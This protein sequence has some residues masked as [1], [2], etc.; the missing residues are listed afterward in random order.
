MQYFVQW[1]ICIWDQPQIRSQNWESNL[2]LCGIKT[3]WVLWRYY[4]LQYSINISNIYYIWYNETI[5]IECRNSH[6]FV[7]NTSRKAGNCLW[8]K[9]SSLYIKTRHAVSFCTT[10][11]FNNIQHLRHWAWDFRKAHRISGQRQRC[12]CDTTIKVAAAGW[13]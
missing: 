9:Y 8:I 12:S 10:G 5:I 3:H 13:Q 4:T 7:P 6:L 1:F 2:P 11:R